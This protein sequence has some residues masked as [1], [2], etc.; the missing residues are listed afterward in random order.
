MQVSLHLITRKNKSG[1]NRRAHLV[2]AALDRAGCEISILDRDARPL[3]NADLIVQT[4]FAPTA[5]LKAAVD[6]RLPYIIAECPVF[7][8]DP[9]INYNN[10]VSWGYNGLCGTAFHPPAPSEELWKPELLPMKTEGPAIIFAQKPNDRSLRG[11]DHSAWIIDKLAQ[12]PDAEFRPHPLMHPS[13]D[14]MEP[15]VDALDRCYHAITY[16]STAGA[17]AILRG[18]VS[19]PEHPGS[20]GWQGNWNRE[21]WLHERSWHGFPDEQFIDDKRVGTYILSGY[22][23]ARERARQG[24]VEIPRLK[25][26]VDMHTNLTDD[27]R[28]TETLK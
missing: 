8:H 16:T 9:A 2:A 7:R 10:W 23:E 6:R 19:F 28:V 3:D 17:E 4:G 5:A 11:Q 1:T 14:K 27:L 22:D 18:C 21:A 25:L 12:Y 15:I 24:L 20:W 26:T 13:P